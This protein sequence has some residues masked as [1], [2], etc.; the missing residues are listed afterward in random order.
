MTTNSPVRLALVGAGRI[1]SNHAE[2][3]AR[4]VPGA[5]LVAVADPTPNADRLAADLDVAVVE[6]SAD[7]VLDRTDVDAVLIT[8]PARTHAELVVAAAAAGKHVFVEKPMA[9]TL[10]E[11][12]RAVAA[13][14]D[15]GVVLQV[16]FNRRFAPGWVAA[17]AAIDAGRVGIPQ[18][19]RSVTRDPGPFSADPARIPPGTIFLETL[20]HDFDALCFLNPGARPLRVTALADALIRPDAKS[21]GHLDTAVV[22]IEFDNGA[23]ATAE[24]SF[25]A[26]YGYDVRA[27]VFGSGGMVTA[28]DARATD[29]TYYGPNGIG[30]DTARR[31]TDLLRSAYLAE[32]VA[33]TEAIRSGTPAP[34]TGTDARTALSIALAAVRSASTRGPVEI[35]DVLAEVTA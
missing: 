14:A 32:F 17:R 34:V 1:G 10:P 27:E 7:A 20:I 22:T 25:S 29:M 3:V 23:I 26:L 8:T 9:V 2:L 15:A 5:T 28:G 12:D 11:A 21:A 6:R 24:A 30:V 16:G 18:L 31:D 35:A 19:L 13:A 4:H 33:F